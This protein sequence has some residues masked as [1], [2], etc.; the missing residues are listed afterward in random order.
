[1]N[2]HP[3]AAR[4]VAGRRRSSRIGPRG[5][6]LSDSGAG[7]PSRPTVPDH[8]IQNFHRQPQDNGHVPAFEDAAGPS[9]QNNQ[10]SATDTDNHND[11]TSS[12]TSMD[13][14]ELPPKSGKKKRFKCIATKIDGQPC[15]NQAL[16]FALGHPHCGT[17][18]ECPGTTNGIKCSVR[19]RKAVDYCARHATK[20]A[21]GG[22]PAPAE[23][24]R[25]QNNERVSL[26]GG[27]IP[28]QVYPALAA[29]LEKISHGSST[30]L[31]AQAR[32]P[33]VNVDGS[34]TASRWDLRPTHLG[35]T[36]RH[37]SDAARTYLSWPSRLPTH[38]SQH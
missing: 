14:D 33:A 8:T 19:V 31:Q 2:P 36:N 21:I 22:P 27:F 37:A 4:W 34:V 1:M 13:T 28:A 35:D 18:K 15:N 25:Q 20:P 17:H 5:S 10:D 6:I 3:V 30:K 38:R 24:L 23:A 29:K 26:R 16:P 12:V 7:Q 32:L 11:G 9:I